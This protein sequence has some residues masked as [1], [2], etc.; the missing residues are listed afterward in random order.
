MLRVDFGRF[1]KNEQLPSLCIYKTFLYKIDVHYESMMLISSRLLRNLYEN[2]NK[3]ISVNIH[4][5]FLMWLRS[6][7]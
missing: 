1:I 4:G 6:N 3:L 5:V 7:M 2:F